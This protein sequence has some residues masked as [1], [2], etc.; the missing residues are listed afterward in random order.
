[1]FRFSVFMKLQ[2]EVQSSTKRLAAKGARAEYDANKYVKPH[3]GS[4]K[5]THHL[6]LDHGDIKS[7]DSVK[8]H[9][10]EIDSSGNHFVHVSKENS[11]KTV[12]VPQS[13]LLKNKKTTNKGFEKEGA[14]ATHLQKHGLMKR[15]G[16]GFTAGNDFELHDH[17]TNKT[18]RGSSGEHHEHGGSSRAIQSEHKSDIKST[19]FGQITV[20]KHPKTGQWHISDNA[21]AK[22]PEFAKA[23]ESSK[24]KSSDGKTR[25]LLDHMNKYDP[26]G[27]TNKSGGY[28]EHTDLHPAHA[29]MRDHH[30]HVAHIDSHGTFTAGASENKDHHDLGLPKMEGKGRF[31]YR[32]KQTTNPNSRSIQFGITDL[33]KSHT[34][35]GTDEGVKKMKNKL[36]HPD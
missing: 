27:S 7:G 11:T 36:G 17:R 6:A 4:E 13:S 10:H 24:V 20:T 15:G 16:A 19:A 3:V 26:P 22:R 33:K 23:V 25:S 14:L 30:V 18:I 2:E 5:A 35:I 31:R 21:R 1:M 29:Y 12:K 32:Q 28:S 9:K 8:I 34:N